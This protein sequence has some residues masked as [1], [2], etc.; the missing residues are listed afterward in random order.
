MCEYSQLEIEFYFDRF[1]KQI[2]SIVS[3]Y[4]KLNLNILFQTD[5]TFIVVDEGIK[6]WKIVR[7]NRAE[8]HNFR[9]SVFGFV[10]KSDGAIF[11]AASWKAPY[12]KGER[13]IKGYVTDE[14]PIICCDPWGI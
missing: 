11:K 7:E 3:E 1:V 8:K 12:L 6:F 5:P 13:A 14:N 10:R 4:E 9:R 2:Q